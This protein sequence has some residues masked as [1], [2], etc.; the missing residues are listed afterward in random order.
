M[1]GGRLASCAAGVPCLAIVY[2]L[3]MWLAMHAVQ[4][5]CTQPLPACE[6]HTTVKLLLMVQGPAMRGWATVSSNRGAVSTRAGPYSRRLL[7]YH[8]PP[9]LLRHNGT[10]RTTIK[11]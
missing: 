9:L 3:C 10:L 7:R 4:V 8:S 6:S 1:T 5:S 2:T 11:P